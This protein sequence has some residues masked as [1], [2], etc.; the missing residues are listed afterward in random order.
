MMAEDPDNFRWSYQLAQEYAGIDY[1]E[2]LL[3]LCKESIARTYQ[4]DNN[5]VKRYRGSFASGQALALFNLQRWDEALEL[6]NQYIASDEIYDL[7]KAKIALIA[8]QILFLQEQYSDCRITA[9]FYLTAYEKL[10]KIQ[11]L[12]FKQGGVFLMDVFAKKFVDS[13][14]L[15]L[16]IIDSDPQKFDEMYKLEETILAEIKKLEAEGNIKEAAATKEQLKGIIKNT[17]G[18]ESLHI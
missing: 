4:V 17:F 1:F 10:A 7:A 9:D 3:E 13:V 18:I 15:Y 16:V 14:R 6:Y 5:D 8:T 2:D 12:T 11:D